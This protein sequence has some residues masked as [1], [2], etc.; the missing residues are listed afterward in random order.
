M[1]TSDTI[2]ELATAL[3]KAQ[4]EISNAKF[5]STN[6]HFKSRYAT[7]AAVRDS[8]TPALAANG[9][10]LV[11]AT[12]TMTDGLHL[13]TRLVHSSGQWIESS[14]PLIN[15]PGKPQIMGSAL[16]YARRYSISALCNIA[17]E[18]DDDAEAAQ[19]AGKQNGNGFPAGNPSAKT[20]KPPPT[21]TTPKAME[22]RHNNDMY[23]QFQ[24]EIDDLR[25]KEQGHKW[26]SMRWRDIDEHISPDNMVHLSERYEDKMAVLP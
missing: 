24:R 14:Y 16:T 15:D 20:Y 17:S 2:N 5:D 1:R 26:R 6:P 21:A 23:S 4:A 18:E 22:A 8:V 11:Q 12:I 9:I 25:T 10:A 13:T 19:D 7:L 3:A